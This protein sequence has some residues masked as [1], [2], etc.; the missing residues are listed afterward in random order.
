MQDAGHQNNKKK[1]IK[2]DCLEYGSISQSNLIVLTD[3]VWNF[4]GWI[5]FKHFSFCLKWWVQV[6]E[7]TDFRTIH[8]EN[9]V[10][11]DNELVFA[12]DFLKKSKYM[13]L[14][15]ERWPSG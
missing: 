9:D 3:S 14:Y 5:I 4:L 1:L 10:L 7:R 2:N 11:T 13:C 15:M 12:R 8:D 6:K